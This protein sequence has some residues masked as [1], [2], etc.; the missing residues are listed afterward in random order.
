[1]PGG[2]TQE[3]SYSVTGMPTGLGYSGTDTDGERVP[4][5][6]WSQQSD[7]Q[8]R[9]AF[10]S[11]P[12]AGQA[13]GATSEYNR[14]Y[15]YDRAG[16]L[17]KVQDRTA[18]LGAELLEPGDTLEAG[19]TT[20]PC[21]TRSYAFDE[22]GNR[23]SRSTATSGSSG[24]CTTSGGFTDA[25]TYDGADRVQNGANSTGTYQYDKLGRQLT[26]PGIDTPKGAAVGNLQI[27]YYQN[28]L[29]RSLTQDGVTTT[30]GLDPVQR[31]SAATTVAGSTTTTVT[32][33]YTDSSDNP[34]WVTKQVGTGPVETSWYGSS[35]GG[36]LGVTVVDD[37]T[38]TTTSVELADLHGDV[39]LPVTID[40]TGIVEIGGYSD[41]DEYGRPLAG[42]TAP[43]TGGVSYGWVGDKERATDETTG[44]MLMGVRLYNATTGLFTSVDPVAGGN[45]T[46]YVYPQDPISDFD[47]DGKRNSRWD[48]DGNKP[49]TGIYIVTKANG[50]VYVGRAKNINRRF[51]EH[52]RKNI[53]G[54]SRQDLMRAV[55]IPT[56][57]NIDAMRMREQRTIDTMR[58]Q[59]RMRGHQFLNGR[60]EIRIN[61]PSR[62]AAR[63][64][65][66]SNNVRIQN[67]AA[68]GN[69]NRALWG[70][71]GYVDIR[72]RR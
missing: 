4:L 15:E 60:N 28:D 41:Y 64:A 61:R 43:D 65:Y 39:A 29:V 17:V 45:T 2:I 21:V 36:D 32:R 35:L 13:P 53:H 11:T 14:A 59:T 23:L 1:M 46:D 42:T 58:F 26:I 33:H 72:K 44:L 24:D 9:V 40:G 22:R 50:D 19:E 69:G 20:T 30:F 12:T 49:R 52:M 7:I 68:Y 63:K 25:W 8:G 5:V 48:P 34:G 55:R 47:I 57:G 27:G 31:R 18:S 67:W 16:R 62:P 10:E 54:F 66:P 56:S 6:A 71:S 38:A 51:N 70:N 3:N 37:G